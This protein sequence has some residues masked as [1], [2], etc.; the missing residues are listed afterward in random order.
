MSYA[1]VYFLGWSFTVETLLLLINQRNHLQRSDVQGSC[2]KRVSPFRYKQVGVRMLSSTTLT[3]S[4][5][6]TPVAAGLSVEAEDISWIIHSTPV[7]SKEKFLMMAS[8]ALVERVFLDFLKE[9][10]G[11]SKGVNEDSNKLNLQS[12]KVF[13]TIQLLHTTSVPYVANR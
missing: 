7:E 4:S 5:F 2:S 8:A 13:R 6:S 12:G 9:I 1:E 10:E 11:Q 3:I